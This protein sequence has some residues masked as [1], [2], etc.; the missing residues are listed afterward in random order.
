MYGE[1]TPPQPNNYQIGSQHMA[2]LD[3]PLSGEKGSKMSGSLSLTLSTDLANA[4]VKTASLLMPLQLLL[5]LITSFSMSS[6]LMH[7]AMP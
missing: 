5:H 6:T 4:T 2:S 7:L 1:E 3:A